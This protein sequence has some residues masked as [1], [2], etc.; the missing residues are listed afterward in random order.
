M[1]AYDPGGTSRADARVAA[2]QRALAAAREHHNHPPP[3]FEAHPGQAGG[4]SGAGALQGAG[5]SDLYDA[6]YA[7]VEHDAR[8]KAEIAGTD[9]QTQSGSGSYGSQPRSGYGQQQ[10]FQQQ[11][12]AAEQYG[13]Y[14]HQQPARSPYQ[15]YE[16]QVYAN[17]YQ[18]GVSASSSSSRQITQTQGFHSQQGFT[19]NRTHYATGH[20]AAAR[21]RIQSKADAN[22]VRMGGTPTDTDQFGRGPRQPSL[23]MASDDE[24]RRTV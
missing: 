14:G 12:A 3:G 1:P 21:S 17:Q 10:G 2:R 13:E 23:N 11:V 6:Y 22:R 19:P 7:Q 15:Q 24:L 5:V 8:R 9:Y 18:G 20:P 4:R 16:R